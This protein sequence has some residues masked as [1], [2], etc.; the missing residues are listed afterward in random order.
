MTPVAAAAP[1]AAPAGGTE[2]VLVAED[3]QL[4]RVLVQK[5]LEQA[6]Y[7]VLVSEGGAQALALARRH[8]GSIH[9][10]ITDVVMPG[11]N[12]RELMQRLTALR[13]GVRVLYMSGYSDEAI[14]RHGVLDAGTAFLQK[15]FTPGLLTHKVREV[16]EGHPS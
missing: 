9:L 4:V 11:M 6:G 16:L 15:P 12:G 5:V 14:A 7:T 10:L 13:P 3:E 1:V 8:T 2:T